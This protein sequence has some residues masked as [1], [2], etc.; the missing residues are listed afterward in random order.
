MSDSPD[1]RA[2][3]EFQERHKLITKLATSPNIPKAIWQRIP[4]GRARAEQRTIIVHK[5]L[6]GKIR[7]FFIERSDKDYEL[8]TNQRERLDRELSERAEQANPGQIFLPYY[9]ARVLLHNTEEGIFLRLGWNDPLADLRLAYLDPGSQRHFL[10]WVPR[11][12]SIGVYQLVNTNTSSVIPLYYQTFPDREGSHQR[13]RMDEINPLIIHPESKSYEQPRSI[14]RRFARPGSA[15]PDILE[16][17][18]AVKNEQISGALRVR[19]ED[20][21]AIQAVLTLFDQ[22]RA[23]TKDDTCMHHTLARDIVGYYDSLP[24]TEGKVDLRISDRK[25]YELLERAQRQYSHIITPDVVSTFQA[26][27]R[28]IDA[29]AK[30][31]IEQRNALGA[32]AE[33]EARIRELAEKYGHV[34]ANAEDAEGNLKAAYDLVDGLVAVVDGIEDFHNYLAS[35]KKPADI[36]PQLAKVYAAFDKIIT[37]MRGTHKAAREEADN[38]AAKVGKLETRAQTAETKAADIERKALDYFNEF[39]KR[40]EELEGGT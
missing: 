16:S 12:E 10:I 24:R 30:K 21:E 33:R 20:R 36:P 1:Q 35:Q 18:S 32:L 28:R 22:A 19:E 40:L 38:L 39:E 26:I 23:D 15:V 14:T 31:T 8:L 34:L 29:G 3:E 7:A 9:T 5:D 4:K 27:A 13:L 25:L 17:R 2:S 6:P 37:G 11:E